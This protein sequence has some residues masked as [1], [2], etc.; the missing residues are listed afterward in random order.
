[1]LAIVPFRTASAL[2][3]SV[4]L[5]RRGHHEALRAY[6]AGLRRGWTSGE[7]TTPPPE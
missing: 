2:K 1:M 6:W 4:A 3:M 5:A 7:A